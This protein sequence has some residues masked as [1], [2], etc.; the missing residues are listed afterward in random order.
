[1]LQE[2]EGEESVTG[3]MAGWNGE[4]SWYTKQI[5]R[6]CVQSWIFLRA[7]YLLPVNLTM[8][9]W[10]GA[11]RWLLENARPPSAV[12]FFKQ[13]KVIASGRHRS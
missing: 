1:M 7:G 13:H 3:L 9:D 10:D 12:N 6:K 4:D 2:E 5:E 11:R 8:T